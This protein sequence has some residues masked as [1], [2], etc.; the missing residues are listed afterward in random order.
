M[1]M[2]LI[3]PD[4][5]EKA[6]NASVTP[7]VSSHE[8]SDTERCRP[9]EKEVG[10]DDHQQTDLLRREMIKDSLS[11]IASTVDVLAHLQKEMAV[12]CKMT[13]WTQKR[14]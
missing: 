13:L 14:N 11:P 3:R 2:L 10:G 12:Y 8:G 6:Q 5:F 7:K 4:I 1:R 9:S